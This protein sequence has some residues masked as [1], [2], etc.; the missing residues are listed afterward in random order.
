[1]IDV[2]RCEMFQEEAEFYHYPK[3]ITGRLEDPEIPVD[4]FNHVMS[5]FRYTM[6]NL[7][8]LDRK[9]QGKPGGRALPKADQAVHRSAVKSTGA[10]ASRY[11]PRE[12]NAMA[13]HPFYG[14]G[15]RVS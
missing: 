7:S 11:A 8:V 15:R 2:T 3:K 10:G 5:N 12:D 14:P 1:M 9:R 13:T 6:M 4:D